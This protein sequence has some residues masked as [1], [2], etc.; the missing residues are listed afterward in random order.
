MPGG[1]SALKPKCKIINH[2]LLDQARQYLMAQGRLDREQRT[3]RAM[4]DIYCRGVHNRA[5]GLCAEC[6]QLLDYA[7]Q[8]IDRCPFKENKP[9][10]A[11][12]T[13]HCYKPE[14]REEIRKVMR[15]AGPR[16]L[17]SHPILTAMHYIDEMKHARKN[18]SCGPEND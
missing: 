8:R 2:H 14:M 17:L 13:V 11:K 10:C 16:M 6:R 9:A 12:C 18:K 1:C 4:I 5:E 15:Y 3:I 7:I